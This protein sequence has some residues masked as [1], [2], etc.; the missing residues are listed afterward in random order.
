MDF[1]PQQDQALKDVQKWLAGDKQVFRLFGYAGTGKTTLAKHLRADTYAAFTGKAAHVLKQKGCPGA[2][3]IHSLIYLPREKSQQRLLELVREQKL[4]PNDDSLKE[5]ILAERENLKRPSF[6]LN[7]DNMLKHCKLLVI[8]ECSMVGEEIA[9]DL[10]SFG[11]KILVLGDPAQLPPVRGGGYFT[12]AKPDVLL[13]QVHRHALDNPIYDLATTV[14]TEGRLPRHHPC[15]YTKLDWRTYIEAGQV[16]VGK[17]ATRQALNKKMREML[18]FSGPLPQIEDKII[19]TRNNHELGLLNGATYRITDMVGDSI[20]EL[21]SDLMV[22]AHM[23]PFFGQ[24]VEPW[25]ARDAEMFDFG[26]AITCH[27]AQGSQ[28]ARV[29]VKDESAVF[30]NNAARWLYTAITRAAEELWLVK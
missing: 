14:R 25:H 28:W 10:M 22:T 21:D 8:D 16:I 18:G 27:K 24:E 19:C 9:R 11:C 13:T 3:T 17:N 7:T 26:Y 15:I 23:E 5:R 4:L 20:L 6:T 29:V 12:N 1:N 2:T 30:R